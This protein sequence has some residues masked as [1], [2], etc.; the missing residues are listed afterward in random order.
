MIAVTALILAG[1]F[2]FVH[3]QMDESKGLETEPIYSEAPEIPSQPAATP[4]PAD[5]IDPPD[6]DP[7]KDFLASNDW[8][9]ESREHLLQQWDAL[10]QTSKEAL[11]KTRDFLSFGAE[12]RTMIEEER[13]LAGGAASAAVNTLMAFG[14]RLG[15]DLTPLDTSA[16]S[17]TATPDS[18]NA[19]AP[20]TE[21]MPPKP[22]TAP[23]EKQEKK[24]LPAATPV[25]TAPQESKNSEDSIQP[26]ALI[27][28]APITQ[29]ETM[30]PPERSASMSSA[31]LP[32]KHVDRTLIE[33]DECRPLTSGRRTPNCRDRLKNGRQGPRMRLLPG[34]RFSMGRDDV[35]DA[36]PAHRVNI[37]YPF[38]ITMHEVSQKEYSLYCR[39][40]GETCPAQPWKDDH[41]PVVNVSRD[42]AKRYAEWLSMQSS[43]G[44]R[45]PTEAE[46]EYAARAGTTTAYPLPE[47]DLGSY[48]HFSDRHKE[49][50]PLPR[51]PQR[52]N[53]N[54]FNLFHMAGNVREWVLDSWREGYEAAPGD[55]SPYLNQ[56]S[57]E[58]VV[59]GGSYADGKKALQSSARQP[60]PA[61]TKDVFTGFRLVRDIYLSPT[62][63]N[64]TRWG[65]WWLGFQQDTHF[66]LQLLATSDPAQIQHLLEKYPD[67]FLKVISSPQS[68]HTYLLLHGLYDSMADAQAADQNLPETLK[69]EVTGSVVK[70]ISELR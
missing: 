44:Y 17:Q 26:E 54:S 57:S 40:T 23:P 14:A 1:L 20:P 21:R 69:H 62:R 45:L 63:T 49:A 46:W 9:P 70:P 37:A 2:I 15:L 35:A 12:L 50:A 53:P 42:D 28:E 47:S 27:Q 66:T 8:S 60:L 19:A 30:Q 11:R 51:K 4:I 6:Y 16:L 68:A 10:P 36:S 3:F 18:P 38:A 25:D 5:H 65:D 24:S 7:I 67:H 33:A 39:E 32:D 29:P 59:R 56:K 61:E 43:R 41:L 52:T 13:G 31:A 64:L 34:S 48:A 58:G 22:T 55:G